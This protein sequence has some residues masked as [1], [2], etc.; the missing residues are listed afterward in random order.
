MS[1]PVE[2]I[3]SRLDI[4]DIIGG[5]LRLQ[6]AGINFKGLCPF[7]GEKTPSF[8][9]SPERQTWHCFGC[10]K[11]GDMFAFIME[12]D[13]LEFVDALRILAQRAG[14]ELRRQDDNFKSDRGRIEEANELATQFFETQLERSTQGAEARK[15]LA[16][17]GLTEETIKKFRLGFIPQN[18][19]A[20]LRFLFNKGFSYEEIVKAG[21][22]IQRQTENGANVIYD[23]F[24]GRIIFP[25]FDTHGRILGFTGRIFGTEHSEQEPKYLNTPETSVFDKGK[26]LYGLNFARTAIRNENAA[27]LVEGQMDLIMS[28]QAGVLNAV[29]TSGTALTAHHLKTIKRYTDT[30]IVA[31][32]SDKAGE[33]AAKRGIDLALEED[34]MVRVAPIV[35]GKDPADLVKEAPELWLDLVKNNTQP[36]IGYF[37]DRACSANDVD[38]PEGKRKISSYILP[39]IV[40][41]ANNIEQAHWIQELAQRLNIKE[42][43]VWEEMRKITPATKIQQPKVKDVSKVQT[44]EQQIS[45]RRLQL[46]EYLLTLLLRAAAEDRRWPLDEALQNEIHNYFVNSISRS[47]VLLLVNSLLK[48]EINDITVAMR[49]ELAQEHAAVFDALA[50]K[51]SLLDLET[52]ILEEEAEK[53]LREIRLLGLHE[54]LDALSTELAFAERAG[55]SARLSQIEN[56]F[57]NISEELNHVMG[58]VKVNIK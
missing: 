41:V 45:S 44:Q 49:S 40:R 12:M 42:E 53:C 43:V 13:G 58:L 7:H 9:V 15:Y 11:G 39:L 4:V 24:R 19:D 21:L 32:D 36:I 25:I 47:I 37:I 17:R 5:Y 27:V 28:H 46:E 26:I 6:K 10:G 33:A 30:L 38:S 1:S 18:R 8:F 2:E 51:S 52:L 34:L 31:F 22:A 54:R 55:D 50:I 35:G 56:D 29:A 48:E 3:K 20:I 57:K 14:V 23:R 16:D